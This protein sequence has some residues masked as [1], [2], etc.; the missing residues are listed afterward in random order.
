M[1]KA[2]IMPT[3]DDER[4]RRISHI[5]EILA[6]PHTGSFTAKDASFLAQYMKNN[7]ADF[8]MAQTINTLSHPQFN[9]P[10]RVVD[11]MQRQ[12]MLD[13]KLFSA[14]SK[15]RLQGAQTAKINID[16]INKLAGFKTKKDFEKLNMGES[17]VDTTSA[18]THESHSYIENDKQ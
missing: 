4:A 1:S 12:Q 3:D 11:Y 14:L 18:D 13:I 8:I 10:D 2:E 5:T 6:K 16:Q 9:D 17:R 7:Y 15:E